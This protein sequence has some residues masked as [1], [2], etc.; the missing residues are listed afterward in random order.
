M[1]TFTLRFDDDGLGVAKRIEFDARDCAIALEIAGDELEDRSALLLAD[2]RPLCRLG[3]SSAGAAALWLVE[4][5]AA[6][7]PGCLP[8]SSARRQVS[9]QD[10]MGA[11]PPDAPS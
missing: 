3:R 2:G 11:Q 1:P 6:A 7:S 8:T 10:P 9:R 4:S 5:P